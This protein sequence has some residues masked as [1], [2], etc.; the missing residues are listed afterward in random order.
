LD[1]CFW[2]FSCILADT[3]RREKTANAEKTT[4]TRKRK[5]NHHD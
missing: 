5:E 1:L 4:N 2:G 3:S